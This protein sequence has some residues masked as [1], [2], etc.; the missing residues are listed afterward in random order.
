MRNNQVKK[1]NKIKCKKKN[2]IKV[3]ANNKVFKIYQASHQWLMMIS[4]TCMNSKSMSKLYD[5][6]ISSIISLFIYLR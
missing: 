4:L 5:I 1:K 2:K 6:I 3:N